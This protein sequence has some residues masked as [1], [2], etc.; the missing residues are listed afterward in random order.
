M[1]ILFNKMVPS[2]K[3]EEW[4]KKDKKIDLL[5]FD[6]SDKKQ[7]RK[8][9][10]N[11]FTLKFCPRHTH[12]HTHTLRK[13]GIYFVYRMATYLPDIGLGLS[14]GHSAEG[15]C[16]CCCCQLAQSWSRPAHH[17]YPRSW[18]SRCWTEPAHQNAFHGDISPSSEHTLE[19][20]YIQITPNEQTKQMLNNNKKLSLCFLFF[21]ALW[22]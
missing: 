11:S 19:G 21:E 14:W 8:T 6:L 4:K 10:K 17:H 3:Q 12:T 16:Q 2:S 7:P 9:N 22:H 1:V 15:W 5:C 18:S 20:R 13:L